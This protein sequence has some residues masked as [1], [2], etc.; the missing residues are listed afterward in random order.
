ML[1]L[2][3]TFSSDAFAAEYNEGTKIL[4]NS[5]Q[6]DPSVPVT[7]YYTPTSSSISIRLATPEDRGYIGRYQWQNNA[8]IEAEDLSRAES[9]INVGPFSNL[10][11]NTKYT[12]KLA[13]EIVKIPYTLCYGDYGPEQSWDVFT[14]PAIPSGISFL[15]IDTETISLQWTF[16]A[17][18][19]SGTSYTLQRSSD[20][21]AS[22]VNVATQTNHTYTDQGLVHNTNYQYRVRVNAISGRYYYSSIFSVKT[23]QD[24][25]QDALDAANQARDAA[26]AAKASADSSTGYLDGSENGGKS[27]AATYDRANSANNNT[28]Y[29]RN[30]QLPDIK[31]KADIA[32]SKA[33]LAAANT[34]YN[35]QSAAYW[36]YMA[37]NMA[38][39]ITNVQGLNY[40]TCTTGTEFTLIISASDNGPASNLRYR[41]ECNGYDSGW[42]NNSTLTITGLTTTGAKTATVKVSDNPTSPD[43]GNIS[44]ESLTFFKI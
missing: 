14:D 41:V 15:S 37:Q 7:L 19:S 34:T 18:N 39:T 32:T 11:P 29:I 9:S 30:T 28:S 10:T 22:W 44:Q 27:L 24:K 2:F 23:K 4:K 12:F 1:F 31:N 40:A 36:A 13:V 26:N 21:G 6:N 43:N 16:A 42:V 3:I 25:L 35:N 33:T 20:S 17:S 5:D 8:Y 38:P